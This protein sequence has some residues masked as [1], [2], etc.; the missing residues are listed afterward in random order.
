MKA[1]DGLFCAGHPKSLPHTAAVV[2][3]WSFLKG[4]RIQVQLDHL[5]VRTGQV[6]DVT[7]DGRI[8]WI[9]AEGVFGRQLIDQRAG[10]RILM[11]PDEFATFQRHRSVINSILPPEP[12]A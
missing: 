9:S 8:L 2:R 4:F 6:E 11:D 10:Y 5:V 12:P 3:D 1:P 7:D